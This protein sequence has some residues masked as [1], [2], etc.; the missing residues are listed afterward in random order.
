MLSISLTELNGKSGIL[1]QEMIEHPAWHGL[2][3]GV[4]CEDL[5]RGRPQYSYLLRCGETRFHYYLSYVVKTPF[6]YQ[7]QPF[8]IAIQDNKKGWGYRNG[9]EHWA[10]TLEELIPLVIHQTFEKCIPIIGTLK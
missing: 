5:L 2:L 6:I 1:E 7:H 8:T 9:H 4:E 10:S 3:V